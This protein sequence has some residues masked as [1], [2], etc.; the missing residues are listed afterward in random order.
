VDGTLKEKFKDENIK[1]RIRAKTGTLR[2]VNALAGFGAPKNGRPIVFSVIV[3]SS[4]KGVGIV[5]YADRIVQA[6]FNSCA[7]TQV[8]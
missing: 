5:D 3:N 1:R 7:N 4:Q 2:G 8:P 6:I